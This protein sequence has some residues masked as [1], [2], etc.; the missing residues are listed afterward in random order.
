MGTNVGG[1]I[2][3]FEGDEIQAVV[4]IEQLEAKSLHKREH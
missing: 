2:L 4:L 1:L 3:P